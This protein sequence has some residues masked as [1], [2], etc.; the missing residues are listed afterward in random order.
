LKRLLG[1]KMLVDCDQAAI[2]KDQ[3]DRLDE[4]A[5]PKSINEEVGFLLRI[6]GQPGDILR[7]RLRKK[8]MLKLKTREGIGRAYSEDEKKRMLEEAA[9]ARSP[10]IDNA[11]TLALNAG[12]RDSEIKQLTRAP[13]NLAKRYLS[14]GRAKTEAGTGRTIPLNSD[15][16]AVLSDDAEWYQHIFGVIQP[17]WSVFAFG[18][19]QP[20]DPTKHVTT[21]KTAW[22]MV[23]EK[24]ELKGRWHDNRHTLITELAESGVGDQTIM[25]IAGHL[26]KPGFEG[27]YPQKSPHSGILEGHRSVDQ[28]RKLLNSNGGRGR[29][30]TDNLS[31]QSF[32]SA[33]PSSDAIDCGSWVAHTLMILTALMN[34]AGR[35]HSLVIGEE[36]YLCIHRL[37]EELRWRFR[38]HRKFRLVGGL[39]H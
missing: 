22:T 10:H 26:S 31:V 8:K 32:L 5:S 36:F 16:F 12:M 17:E 33:R 3:N 20:A 15:L 38:I 13:I 23:R 19:P 35:D 14:V 21:P 37:Q 28:N 1:A 27:G 30:R 6:L 39:G 11:L 2:I 29:N 25:D 24:A 34:N 9:R 18:K 7:A 4:K